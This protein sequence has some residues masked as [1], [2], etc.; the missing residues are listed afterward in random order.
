MYY[1]SDKDLEKLSADSTLQEQINDT[2]ERFH[3]FEVGKR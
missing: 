1:L 2:L 3:S